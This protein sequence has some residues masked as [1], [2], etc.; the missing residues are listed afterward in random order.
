MTGW[1]GK[2]EDSV[3]GMYGSWRLRTAA[4]TVSS[5]LMD[6]YGRVRVRSWMMVAACLTVEAWAAVFFEVLVVVLSEEL[7]AECD[8]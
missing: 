5:A 3:Q 6:T 2:T 8:L 4:T 7:A 1:A